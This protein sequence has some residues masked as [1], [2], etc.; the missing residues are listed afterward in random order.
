MA[1]LIVGIFRGGCSKEEEHMSKSK[2]NSSH[3][4]KILG[5]FYGHLAKVQKGANGP[6]RGEMN[7]IWQG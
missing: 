6:F 2:E 5:V 3:R 4:L 1:C 7:R